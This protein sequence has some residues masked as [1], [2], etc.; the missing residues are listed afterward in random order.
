M[1]KDSL[2]EKNLHAIRMKNVMQVQGTTPFGFLNDLLL[3]RIIL[4]T[5]GYH[6]YFQYNKMECG[7]LVPTISI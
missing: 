4:H 6:A 2:P 7:S 5:V 1:N 3:S